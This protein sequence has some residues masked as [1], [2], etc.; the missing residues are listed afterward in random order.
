MV[1]VHLPQLKNQYKKTRSVFTDW[2]SLYK[3][4]RY[5]HSSIPLNTGFVCF[6]IFEVFVTQ[7]GVLFVELLKGTDNTENWDVTWLARPRAA[8]DW[9]EELLKWGSVEETAAWTH[10]MVQSVFNKKKYVQVCS[11][12]CLFCGTGGVVT[13]LLT[14]L[15]NHFPQ[16]N[17][18]YWEKIIKPIL[19][20]IMLNLPCIWKWVIGLEEL[21]GVSF[22][23]CWSDH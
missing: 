8:W 19:I 18:W 6:L 22:V 12:E 13:T 14:I 5:T 11:I 3:I 16:D 10:F 21:Q 2:S 4:S 15:S 20:L 9:Y 1:V 23:P 17:L 7:C